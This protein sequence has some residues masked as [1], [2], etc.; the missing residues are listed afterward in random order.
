MP[1]SGRKAPTQSAT[2]TPIGTVQKGNNG[3]FWVVLPTI[4]SCHWV[5]VSLTK[6]RIY[7]TQTN[8]SSF[9]I[10]VG[11]TRV[12]VFD[13][14]LWLFTSPKHDRIWLPK[15]KRDAIAKHATVLLQIG[16]NK[17]IHIDGH[18]IMQ[19]KTKEPILDYDAPMGNSFLPYPFA[20]TKNLVYLLLEDKYL[21]QTVIQKGNPYDVFYADPIVQRTSKPFSK[22][23]LVDTWAHKQ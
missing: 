2:E 22:A 18:A 19:F 1:V 14:A 23:I 20:L 3:S 21:S 9:R 10:V 17:Y 12:Y 15:S 11:D 5:E 8:G 13:G 7:N 16:Q 6:P 4:K